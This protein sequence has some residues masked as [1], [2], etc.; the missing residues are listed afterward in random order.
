VS[1]ALQAGDR[2]AQRYRIVRP[3]GEGGMG[4][5]YLTTDELLG[6]DVAL[7]IAAGII[8]DDPD[9]A[10]ARQRRE[11]SLARRV[12]H[13]HVARVFDLGVDGGL[14][15]ITMEHV[16]GTSL[17]ARLHP[18]PLVVG[19]VVTIGLQ[20]A[21]ALAAAHD[22]GVVHLDLKP[23]N[24]VIV[25]GVVPRAVLVDFGVS[26]TL[27]ERANGAGTLDYMAPE[28]LGEEAIGGAADVYALGLLLFECLTGERPF[29]AGQ[30]GVLARLTKRPPLLGAPVPSALA[31]LVDACLARHPAER[32]SARV[33]EQTFGRLLARRGQP[34]GGRTDTIGS[35][36]RADT[37]VPAA[38]GLELA[39][40]RATLALTGREA[41]AIAVLDRILA[42]SPGLDVALAMRA[43]ALVRAWGDALATDEVADAAVVAVSEAI[44]LAPHLADTHFADA[45]MADSRG[46]IAYAVRALRRALARDPLHAFSHELLGFL[47][48][49]AAIADTTRLEMA[50][51]LDAA[52][53]A[54]AVHVA[55]EHFFAGRYD[56]GRRLLDRLD[57]RRP[58]N[59]SELLRMRCCVWG[60]RRDEAH[61]LL[62]KLP[63]DGSLV[64]AGTRVVLGWLVGDSGV[65]DVRRFLDL[66]LAMPMAPKRRAFL[67][68]V[69]VEV[70]AAIDPDEAAEHLLHAAQLPLA[71]LRWFDACPALTPLRTLPA[72]QIAR[73]TVQLRVD[74]AF[75]GA[76]HAAADDDTTTVLPDRGAST[77]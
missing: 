31:S 69:F 30:Q 44:A 11:V 9:R 5:V 24:V 33:V 28:Q 35:G 68:M 52:H 36:A 10:F 72:F 2:F 17:R 48:V 46:D 63:D 19:D 62:A 65:D 38:I 53:I 14:L 40:V 66:A 55:R 59:E 56:D 39:R 75:G 54:S 6:E 3:L 47:E 42:A 76:V 45:L 32:P 1:A 50:W 58:S 49:E 77:V 34:G 43:I 13:P 8:T 60:H 64:R 61:D 29:G 16:P 74:E 18:G 7:K 26:R 41:E 22:A 37:T 12:T 57:A 27:G 15:Y 21:S 4:A 20:M 23:G 70:L 67:H 51:A 25:D 71:D 73:A